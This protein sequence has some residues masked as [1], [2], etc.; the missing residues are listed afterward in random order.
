MMQEHEISSLL[1]KGGEKYIG[2]ITDKDFVLKLPK[3]DKLCCDI[4][5]KRFFRLL[6]LSP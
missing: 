4:N 2:I 5:V 3:F 1:V 6:N